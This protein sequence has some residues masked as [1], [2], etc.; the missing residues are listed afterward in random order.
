MA[1]QQALLFI[2]GWNC[3]LKNKKTYALSCL[4]LGMLSN[5]TFYFLTF[6]SMCMCSYMCMCMYVKENTHYMV[7]RWV[8][9]KIDREVEKR[10]KI[11]MILNADL[12]KL[13]LRTKKKPRDHLVQS[14]FSLGFEVTKGHMGNMSRRQLWMWNWSSGMSQSCRWGLRPEMTAEGTMFLRKQKQR[15]LRRT[16]AK[17]WGK[18]ALECGRTPEDTEQW[19]YREQSKQGYK[20]SCQ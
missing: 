17:A 19:E 3:H 14:L 1:W 18:W 11:E 10:E 20:G 2:W 9:L 8:V 15:M 7:G 6:M 16:R 13:S 4:F 5:S 12:L